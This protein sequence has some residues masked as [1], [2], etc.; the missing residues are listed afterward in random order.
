MEDRRD[1]KLIFDPSHPDAD[2]FGYVLTPNVNVVQEM[3]DMISSKRSYEAN[4]TAATAAQ[5][6]A[7]K[8][9][10]LLR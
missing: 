6:M 4:I 7:L 8:S 1:F 10:D 9:L 3:V 2:E 5:N